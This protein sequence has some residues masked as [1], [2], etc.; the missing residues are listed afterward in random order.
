MLDRHFTEPVAMQVG[1]PGTGYAKTAMPP[2]PAYRPPENGARWPCRRLKPYTAVNGA[3]GSEASFPV[4]F[5][6][7]AGA[8]WPEPGHLQAIDN[9]LHS[10]NGGKND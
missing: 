6:C 10:K 4:F 3:T 5:S 2:N 1:M 7:Q 9:L 8:S